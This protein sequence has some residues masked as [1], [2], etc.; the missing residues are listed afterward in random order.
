MLLRAICL[1]G[2]TDCSR[3]CPVLPENPQ[4]QQKKELTRWRKMAPLLQALLH[5]RWASLLRSW[6]WLAPVLQIFGINY[7]HDLNAVVSS[8]FTCSLSHSSIHKETTRKTLVRRLLSCKNCQPKWR[9]GEVRWKY[10][11][12]A[13]VDWSNFVHTWYGIH[14]QRFL[15][16]HSHEETNG[17]FVPWEALCNWVANGQIGISW[18]YGVRCTWKWQEVEF[19]ESEFM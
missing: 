8:G 10:A 17:E 12:W 1:E 14:F 19:Y 18:S 4:S 9:I 11:V 15:G 3:K 16:Y 6:Y 2:I 7:V 13:Y 5:V